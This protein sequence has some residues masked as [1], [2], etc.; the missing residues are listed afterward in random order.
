[1]VVRTA[2]VAVGVAS[3][4]LGAGGG[5]A[6]PTA[7][8]TLLVP[9]QDGQTYVGLSTRLWDTNDSAWEDT[10]PF[11]EAHRRVHRER[12]RR[13]DADV[14]T[15]LGDVAAAR[16]ARQAARPVRRLGAGSGT[17]AE[18][19]RLGEPGLPRLDVDIVDAGERGITVEDVAS[20]RLD[21]YVSEYARSIRAFGEPVLTGTLR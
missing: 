7:A 11:E 1:M 18:R 3:M 12:A 13:Q 6:A 14:P 16:R 17:S 19:D 21:A 20:G 10:R 5:S 2:L 8:V 15:G 4:L 9:P